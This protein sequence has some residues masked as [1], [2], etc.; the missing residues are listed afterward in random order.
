M[1]NHLFKKTKDYYFAD[2]AV[3]LNGDAACQAFL[4]M[5]CIGKSQLKNADAYIKLSFR[6]DV[7]IGATLYEDG[8]PDTSS[9]WFKSMEFDKAIGKLEDRGWVV[10][11]V[12]S[13]T[14]DK[15][16]LSYLGGKPPL[17]FKLPE[18]QSALPF[19]YLGLL[20]DKDEAFKWLPFHLNLTC[21][22]YLNFDFIYLDYTDPDCPIIL[23]HE[24]VHNFDYFGNYL[25]A[26]LYVEFEQV[27]VKT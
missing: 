17:N 24:E 4:K 7:L 8:E 9:S 11:D 12:Y 27:P 21:P 6:N 1:L 25:K 19:Q 26:D 23:N 16:G 10:N 13:I 20:S 3:D 2:W 18:N 15:N 14:P 5:H 22:I